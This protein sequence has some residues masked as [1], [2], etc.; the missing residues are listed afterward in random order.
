MAFNIKEFT[1]KCVRVWH[2]LRKPTMREYKTISK[3][4]ALGLLGIG[5]IGFLISIVINL[6]W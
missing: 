1:A 6:V 3:V 4:A 2:V 5:L